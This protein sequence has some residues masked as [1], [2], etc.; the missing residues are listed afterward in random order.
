ME[1][2][3]DLALVGACLLVIY[4]RRQPRPS[5]IPPLAISCFVVAGIVFAMEMPKHAPP[6]P[7]KPLPKVEEVRKKFERSAETAKSDFLFHGNGFSIQVPQ[8]FRWSKME[9]PVM[10]LASRGDRATA[11]VVFRH[12]LEGDPE[13]VVRQT[14]ELMKQKNSTYDFSPLAIDNGSYFRTW[15][16]VTKNG[17]PLRGMLVFAERD[18]KLWELTL[19]QPTSEPDA[20]L[21]RIAQSWVVD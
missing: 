8:G 12:E 13:P 11:I 2:V 1:Y 7:S 19:T 21:Y 14:L 5:W 6:R 10:L 18:D 20:S 15:F 17:V 16:R 3:L 4:F 9:D